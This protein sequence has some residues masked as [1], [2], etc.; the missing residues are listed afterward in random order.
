MGAAPADRCLRLARLSSPK[1]T[2]AATRDGPMCRVEA[3]ARARPRAAIRLELH[4][5]PPTRWSGRY[6][7]MGNGGFAGRIDRPTLEAASRRGD[8]AGATDTGH[9]GDGFDASWAHGRPDL[10]R[11]Y[12]WA[13]IKVTSDAARL[14]TRVY[15]GRDAR[16]RYFMGCSFGGRQALVAAGRW[17]GDWDGVIAGAPATR[18]L[19]RLAAFA[20]IQRAIRAPGAWLTPAEVEALVRGGG[21]SLLTPAQARG[22]AAIEAAG[23]PLADADAAEWQRWIYNADPAAPSQQT[24]ATQAQRHLRGATAADF[25]VPDLRRFAARGGRVLSYFGGADAVLPPGKAVADARSIGARSSFYRLF[26]VPGMAHCQGGKTPYALGQ[27][28]SA[29]AIVDD[30]EHDVR[31]ALEQWVELRRAPRRLIATLPG[32]ANVQAVLE[33]AFADPPPSRIKR[34]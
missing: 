14:L 6:Y 16:R 29:P 12:A 19:D 5:P 21:R 25:D 17:P 22:V 15:Y 7:Q 32:D 3:V 30:A 33:P 23:Y 34:R 4:L 27:S 2:I 24:F 10:V 26:P 9:A 20:R 11:D 18:W 28:L 8:A 1:L 13:S 31:R